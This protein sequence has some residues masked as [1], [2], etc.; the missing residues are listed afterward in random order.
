MIV[1]PRREAHVQDKSSESKGGTDRIRLRAIIFGLLLLPLIGYWLFEGE[2]ARYTFATWAVPFYNAIFV[3]FLVTLANMG[4]GRIFGRRPFN[5]LELL[6]IYTMVS[7]ASALLSTD[8][9]GILITL[10]GYPVR[11]ANDTNGWRT[12][13][14]GVLPKWLIVTDD[15]ALRDFYGGNSTFFTREHIYAWLAPSLYWMIL[16]AALFIAFLAMSVILRKQWTDAERLTF[17]IVQLPMAMTEQTAGFFGNRL[18]WLGFAIAGGITLL[19]GLHYLH[20][21]IPEI[22]IKRRDFPVFEVPPWNAVGSI[23]IAFYFFAIAIGFLM[24]LDLSVS[25]WVFFILYKLELV[26]TASL[27]LDPTSKVPYIGDQG[28]GAFAAIGISALWSM[29]RHAVNAFKT[30][31]LGGGK[32]EDKDE[33][34]SYRTAFIALILCILVMMVFLNKAG[35][36][37]LTAGLFLGL[38]L[39]LAVV[40]SRVRCELGFPA[41]DMDAAG[42]SMGPHAV[43]TRLAGP[44]SFTPSSLGMMSMLYW[45]SRAFRSHPMPHQLEG[46]RLAGNDGTA[47]RDMLR[48]IL[49]AGM[50]AIPLCFFV[51]L[52]RFYRLGAGTAHVGIWSLGF[53]SETFPRLERWLR[54]PD[55]PIRGRWYGIAVGML[56]AGGLAA[57]RRRMI[58]FP[59][60]PLG[61]A[62]AAGWGMQNLWLPIMIGSVC[63]AVSLWVGGL[64]AYRKATMLFFGLM[65]GEF[66]VGCSWTILG[67]LF[68]IRTYDFWP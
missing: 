62:V 68:G 15:S 38:L 55:I 54:T 18:M 6:C 11:F 1:N 45:A 29:R 22:P 58:G 43:M 52:D 46:F 5:R 7:I 42:E 61:Y 50:F 37:L 60:H 17:P 16:I 56:I 2:M 12:L 41:N 14:R 59:L 47:R 19:N 3:L 49:I 24:P 27:G 44:S 40:I 28:L 31:F 57:L 51:Y 8:F 25:C 10:M 35:M 9:L 32:D 63:K 36:P 66:F 4:I 34:T 23:R 48:A 30:A 26:F 67:M 33:P 65:L 20:P 13:F 39:A 53:G 64:R 21:T